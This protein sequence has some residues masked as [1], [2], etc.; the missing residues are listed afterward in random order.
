MKTKGQV[1]Y[2]I[3]NI[4]LGVILTIASFIMFAD[5]DTYPG[6]LIALPIGLFLWII[7]A[8][9]LRK[10]KKYKTEDEKFSP[11]L[12]IVNLILFILSCIILASVIILP[13]IGPML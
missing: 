7:G 8:I 1:G 13:I 6:P 3:V 10:V 9:T 5:P 4:I 11:K 2:S 12:L